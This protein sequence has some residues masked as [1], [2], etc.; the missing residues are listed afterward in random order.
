MK[1]DMQERIENWKNKKGKEK[2]KKKNSSSQT[3]EDQ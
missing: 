3:K 2:E 1:S